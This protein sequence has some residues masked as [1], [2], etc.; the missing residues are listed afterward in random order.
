MISD[1][2]HPTDQV[3]TTRTCSGFKMDVWVS[4][5]H[6]MC[7]HTELIITSNLPRCVLPRGLRSRHGAVILDSRCGV[8]RTALYYNFQPS[9]WFECSQCRSGIAPARSQLC[10]EKYPLTSLV[11][12]QPAQSM[13][14]G[15]LSWRRRRGRGSAFVG[16]AL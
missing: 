16:S 4:C 13:L 14:G 2:D 6:S 5:M 8:Y 1:R 12:A 7:E 11:P 9:R 15:C 10:D 3:P